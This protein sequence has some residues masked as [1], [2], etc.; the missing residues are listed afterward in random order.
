MGLERGCEQQGRGSVRLRGPGQGSGEGQLGQAGFS[1]PFLGSSIAGSSAIPNV[2][3][4]S[5]SSQYPGMTREQGSD[6]A[7]ALVLGS[8]QEAQC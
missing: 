3:S 4:S 1:S 5:G 8:F 6:L 7:P 2:S